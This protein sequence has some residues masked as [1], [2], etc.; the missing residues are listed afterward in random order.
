MFSGKIKYLTMTDP[1]KVSHARI[2]ASPL[3]GPSHPGGHKE[4]SSILAGQYSA[5]VY[6][7]KCGGRE[8]SCG[9]SA[10]E[11]CCT[12]ERAQINFGDQTLYSI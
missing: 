7:P 3:M 4:M 8:G 9:V 2:N 12:Q 1:K 6:E 11:Y 5:L 10:N